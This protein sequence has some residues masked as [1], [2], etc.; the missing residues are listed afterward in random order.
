[1]KRSN[2]ELPLRYFSSFSR[3]APSDAPSKEFKVEKKIDK[4]GENNGR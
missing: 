4:A 3:S 1:M 2:D